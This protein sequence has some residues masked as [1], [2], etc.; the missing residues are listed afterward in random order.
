[1][2]VKSENLIIRDSDESGSLSILVVWNI[3][4]YVW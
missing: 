4:D 2:S 3:G 1:M